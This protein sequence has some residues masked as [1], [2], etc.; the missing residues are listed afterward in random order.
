M[1]C[2][3]C[4]SA[5]EASVGCDDCEVFLCLNCFRVHQ[6]IK[7]YKH[8][9]V[10]I[11]LYSVYSFSCIYVILHSAMDYA[12]HVTWYICSEADMTCDTYG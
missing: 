10:I 7:S 2:T 11:I 5:E 12:C 1:S 4:A 8:H 6:T 9:E 3:S